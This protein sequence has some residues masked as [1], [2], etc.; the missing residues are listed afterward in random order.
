MFISS[1]T[2]WRM[3]SLKNAS[4][5]VIQAGDDLADGNQLPALT[6]HALFSH[7]PQTTPFGGETNRHLSGRPC[8]AAFP[9]L[10]AG[11]NTDDSDPLGPDRGTVLSAAIGVSRNPPFGGG[12]YRLL[13]FFW[14]VIL[15]SE[16]QRQTTGN[17]R[18]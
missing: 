17:K 10:P 11:I 5:R 15:E 14:I 4:P 1:G 12:R 13:A 3:I 18:V 9:S 16:Y 2:G 6:I 8:E 7:V